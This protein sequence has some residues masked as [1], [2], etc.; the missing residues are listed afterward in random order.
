MGGVPPLDHDGDEIDADI[1]LRYNDK[2][3][4]KN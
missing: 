3:D 2:E 1:G 4:W